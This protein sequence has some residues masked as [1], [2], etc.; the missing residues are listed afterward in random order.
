M[1][2]QLRKS[3]RLS[4]WGVVL[5]TLGVIAIPISLAG[6][7]L[8]AN[9][10]GP[11]A[12][13]CDEYGKSE[14]AAPWFLLLFFAA[15]LTIIAGITMCIMAGIA[16]RRAWR[17]EHETAQ[18]ALVPAGWYADPAGSNGAWRWWNGCSWTEHAAP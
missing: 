16:R 2:A 8:T 5:L 3:F 11:F 15:V 10:C 18:H 17:N 7:L 1:N 14:P 9:A 4:N 6:V 13:G 12:D